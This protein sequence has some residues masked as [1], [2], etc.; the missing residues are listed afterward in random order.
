MAQELETSLLQHAGVLSVSANPISG[1]VLVIYSPEYSGLHVESLIKSCLKEL[2]SRPLS[3]TPATKKASSLSRILR[4]SLPEREDL[5]APLLLSVTEHSL[6][7]LQDLAFVGILNTARGEG[8]SFLQRLGLGKVSSRLAFMT[9]V[10]IVLNSAHLWV[11]Y[12]RRKA[13]QKVAQTTQQRLRTQ[14]ITQIQ[15]QDMAFFDHYGTG[16]LIKLVTEDTAQIGEF[17]ER[18]GDEVI[19]KTLTIVVSGTLL[20]TA[21]PRLAL[22]VGLPLPLIIFSSRYFGQMSAERYARMGEISSRFSQTLENSLVGITDI[23]SFTAEQQEIQ[24]MHDYSMQQAEFYLDAVSVSSLQTQFVGSI[25]SVGYLLAS[26]YG[27]MMAAD[28]S[29]SLS[30]YIRVVYW[31]P[32][33]LR[34]LTS[35]EQLTKLYHAANHASTELAEI[36]DSRPQIRSGSVD[37]PSES[38]RGEVV[39]DDVSFG[40]NP[41]ASVLEN[42]SFQLKHGETLAIVGPT[43]SG[44]STLLRLLLRF[45]DVDSGR[46]MLDGQ[47]IR[48][49][50]LESLRRTVSLVSQD[51]HLFQG[52]IREN[53]LYGQRHASEAQI[54][55]A[56]TD[57][58]A[59]DLLEYLPGG[60][61]AE[62]GERGHKLSGGERQR[63]A[64]ARALLKLSSGASILV[65]DE[66]TSQLDNETEA[67]IKRSLRKAASGKSVIM[68]AHRLSTIRSADRI[69]VLERGKVIE[70]GKHEELLA[71]HGLYASLWHLQNEDPLGGA[72]EVR[73][74]DRKGH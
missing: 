40:Y 12:H 2:S 48:N 59:L 29:I 53:V 47:D 33:L 7:I 27:G 34:S 6:N 68:I 38:V 24:R 74:R 19:Q 51:V 70:E 3:G 11:Q 4:N 20:T 25:F 71:R 1:R 13:W 55:E 37:L 31:F 57:A 41:S 26:G 36:L 5:V 60:L 32:Q 64:I 54:I 28:G 65:L 8:P 10:S 49:L 69:I 45:Y 58:G 61:E 42:V 35:I 56:M 21:S 63:V 72:L 9:G 66:A 15:T 43:G 62:V 67:A 50:N 52:T 14:L 18:A 46:I 22:L 17:V 16:H 73:I 39:F 23:K 44:K 30:E